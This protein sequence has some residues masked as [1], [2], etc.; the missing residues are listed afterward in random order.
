MFDNLFGSFGQARGDPMGRAGSAQSTVT[1]PKGIEL[2]TSKKF[3]AQVLG[4]SKDS[5]AVMY[6]ASNSADI[7]ERANVVA[8]FAEEMKAIFKV[9]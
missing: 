3:K 8:A 1:L 9:S 2:L 7:V 5:W 4:T 6:F